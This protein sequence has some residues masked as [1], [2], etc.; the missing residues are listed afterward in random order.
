MEVILV[1]AVS[2]LGEEGDVV[3]VSNGY[4]RNFLIPKKLAVE[5]TDKKRRILEHE[6]RQSASGEAKGKRNA[7]RLA[8]A[9]SDVTCTIPM[10]AGKT[11]RLFGSVTTMDIASA[12]SE[13]GFEIDRRKIELAEPIKELGAFIAPIRLHPEVTANVRILVIR[14]AS[15]KIKTIQST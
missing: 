1:E 9:L 2:G 3:K 4:A 8:E 13:Q 6:K 15:A 7:E 5:A 10:R 12:I 11:D 14:G